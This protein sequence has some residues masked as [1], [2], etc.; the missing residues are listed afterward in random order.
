MSFIFFSFSYQ[1]KKT[2]LIKQV[3]SLMINVI[4][5]ISKYI[6]ILVIL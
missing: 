6:I 2:Y 3:L 5:D 4:V 1:Q